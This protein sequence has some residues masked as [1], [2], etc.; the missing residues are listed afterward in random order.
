M[1]TIGACLFRDFLP[2]L[3][4]YK[5]FFQSDPSFL[6]RKERF[7]DLCAFS[8]A[9]IMT[10]GL[11]LFEGHALFHIRSLKFTADVLRSGFQEFDLPFARF[12]KLAA[13]V[14]K[15]ILIFAFQAIFFQDF[16]DGENTIVLNFEQIDRFTMPRA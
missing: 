14:S 6:W 1:P 8:Q 4:V 12:H 16:T 10:V 7:V 9:A 5:S 15:A 13:P 2:A 11:N 3:Q